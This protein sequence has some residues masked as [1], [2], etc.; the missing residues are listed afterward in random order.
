MRNFIAS[1]NRLFAIIAIA[2]CLLALYVCAFKYL[3]C[4]DKP[5]NSDAVVLF[6][7]PDYK[8]RLKEAYQLIEDGYAKILIIP[9]YGEMF[10]VVDGTIKKT[11]N[12]QKAPF[13][14]KIYP[15]YYENTHIEALEAKKMMNRAGYTSAIFVS[16]PYHMR[17]ISIISARVFS[18]ENYKLKFIGSRYVQQDSFLS[19]FSWSNVKQ[20]FIE[21]FKIIGFFIYQLYE[22]VVSNGLTD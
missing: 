18:N 3:N 8:E 11:R 14:R 12:H 13:D 7:G 9:A 4:C 20:V 6:I 16:S 5:V 2:G 22:A 10:T 17:R 21:Y 19:I 15:R 1:I